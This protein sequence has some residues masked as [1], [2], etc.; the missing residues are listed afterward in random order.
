MEAWHRGPPPSPTLQ[1]K[2]QKKGLQSPH[3]HPGEP[4]DVADLGTPCALCS[5]APVILLPIQI[6]L[7]GLSLREALPDYHSYRHFLANGWTW[8]SPAALLS[9]SSPHPKATSEPLL[10][11]PTAVARPS[12]STS[13][14]QGWLHPLLAPASNA[15]P[16]QP[17]HLLP[18]LLRPSG[19][20]QSVPPRLVRACPVT[21]APSQGTGF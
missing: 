18:S 6:Q 19:W 20:S 2:E 17:H 7:R 11:T 1:G 21:P 9:P 13:G 4:W 8:G 10:S 15:T 5:S 14:L 3:P 16:A 12:C